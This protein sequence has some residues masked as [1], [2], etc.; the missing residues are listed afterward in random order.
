MTF[1]EQLAAARKADGFT[2][3]EIAEALGVTKASVS[4]YE[5]SESVTETT[6][7]AYAAALGREVEIAI[8]A[9]RRRATSA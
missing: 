3:S 9:R 6:V 4:G 8:S 2:Q 7:R 1:G 5:R